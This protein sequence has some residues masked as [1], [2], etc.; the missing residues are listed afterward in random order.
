MKKKPSLRLRTYIIV[1]DKV[2]TGITR[3]IYRY[4]KYHD[5]NDPLNE[6]AL[7]EHLHREIINELSE[8]VN[9]GDDV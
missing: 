3:G 4:L 8:A 1:S 6:E 5:A 7:A 2:E 9:F